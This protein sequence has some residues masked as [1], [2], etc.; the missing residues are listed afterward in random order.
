MMK[1]LTSCTI[2]ETTADLVYQC[3]RKGEVPKSALSGRYRRSTMDL[4]IDD[5]HR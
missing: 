5:R 4:D 1:K 3:G 2:V